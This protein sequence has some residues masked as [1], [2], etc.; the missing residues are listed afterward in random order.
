M[1]KCGPNVVSLCLGE[2]ERAHLKRNGQVRW[3]IRGND[4]EMRKDDYVMMMV[5]RRRWRRRR[6]TTTTTSKSMLSKWR[7]LVENNYPFPPDMPRG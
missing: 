4:K 7:Q 5:R 3:K 2:F 6:T 1:T